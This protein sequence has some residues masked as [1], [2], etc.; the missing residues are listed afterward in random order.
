MIK[1]SSA[2]QADG[3]IM[4]DNMRGISNT[5][6]KWLKANSA[7]AESN[8]SAR[9]IPTATGFTLSSNIAVNTSGATYIYIAIR[10]PMKTPESGTS[11][12]STVARSGTSATATI[13]TGMTPDLFISKGRISGYGG[14]FK[15]RLRGTGAALDSTVTSAER[16]GLTNEVLSFNMD[17]VT[18][19][20]DSYW[21]TN[22][23][24]ATYANW[25]FRRAPGFFDVVCYTGDSGYS[26]QSHNLAVRPEL[27][28]T[29]SRSST[30]PGSPGWYVTKVS[31]P[32]LQGVGLYGRLDSTQAFA[33]G[34][35]IATPTIFSNLYQ[36]PGVTYVTYLFATL[37][38]VSKVG[39]YTG[40]GANLN[41]DCG[42]SAGARFVLIKRTDA[43]GDWY[44]W[45]SARGIVSSND[46]YL[47]LNS[48][49][50]ENT[51]TDYIDPL[52]SGFTVT[53]SA[54]AALNA[55]GGNYI[56][57]AIA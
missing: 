31:N 43:S 7:N 35:I 20:S 3:W 18:V 26:S 12:F 4:V 37:A 40:T 28:I 23:S 16:T 13:T 11:V 34:G 38:G 19:G 2:A 46:P 52:A 6:N 45:D 5:D 21:D 49:A 14:S 55:S 24:G 10:R 57:L 36:T 29:K 53:S 22:Y 41:V 54:P 27:V 1:C 30:D 39:S 33:S 42:F 56:F 44:V 50:A 51:S 48:T 8:E 47:L 17:G 9:V 32:Y 15:D 25:F